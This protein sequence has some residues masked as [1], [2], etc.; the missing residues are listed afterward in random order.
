MGFKKIIGKL[1]LW[2]GLT[3]GLVVFIIAMTGCLY[4]FK[5]EIEN[6]VQSYRFVAP[7]A[8]V[9]YLPS[10]MK[11]IAEQQL[12]G[13]N[14]HAVLYPGEDRA[15]RAIFYQEEPDYYYFYVYMN[16]YTGEVLKVKDMN[17]DFFQFIIDGHFYLWLPHSIGQKV[18]AT[19][20][21]I[22]LVM[23]I[24]GL[25]LWWPKNKNATKQRFTIKWNARWRRKNYDL[26]NVL[27]FYVT[28]VAIILASTGL[29]W[30]FQWFAKTVYALAGGEKSTVYNEPLSDTTRMARS[31]LPP[32]DRVFEKMKAEYPDETIIEVHPP[33]NASSVI[34]ANANPDLG[35]YWKRDFRYF[36]QYSL[37]ELPVDHLYGRFENADGADKLIRMNY[38]I[39]VGAILGL[40]G[41][42]IAF[43]ASLLCASLPVTG[44]YIWWGRQNRK[45]VSLR[46]ISAKRRNKAAG[47]KETSVAI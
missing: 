16:Q 10:Q 6:T 34:A 18:T 5:T 44:V 21:L 25:F 17:A 1:H 2:L 4:A 36:D 9:K 19:A 32:I 8:V 20:T 26:H 47:G 41:K 22:F 42:I 39:H 24:T 11:E 31:G 40:P 3:S 37:V 35:T 12:P 29:V 38:D 13:K 30:G 43:M 33:V 45:S 46:K 7:E 23:I 15:V 28:W 27:G 14:I